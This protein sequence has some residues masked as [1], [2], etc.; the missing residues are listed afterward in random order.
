MSTGLV[1]NE[2][3]VMKARLVSLTA[4][5]VVALA[6][7]ATAQTMSNDCIEG[8][9]LGLVGVPDIVPTG[10]GNAGDPYVYD[11]SGIDLDMDAYDF[12]HNVQ[13][14]ERIDMTLYADS[15]TNGTGGN[16]NFSGPGKNANGADLRGVVLINTTN[17]LAI[18]SATLSITNNV[19]GNGGHLT[20]ISSFGSITVSEEIDTRSGAQGNP[21][22]EM[23]GNVL[24]SAASGNVTVEGS[25]QTMGRTAG[26]VV[27]TGQNVSVGGNI[28]TDGPS[29]GLYS[30]IAGDISITALNGDVVV[31]GWCSA[32]TNDNIKGG[33][34]GDLTISATNG[35]ISLGN[36]DVRLVENIS[37][38]ALTTATITGLIEGLIVEV[39][40]GNVAGA[41]DTDANSDVHY[42][43]DRQQVVGLKGN[44][45]IH[46]L[47]GTDTGYDLVD[48]AARCH[49]RA[50]HPS[51]LEMGTGA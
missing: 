2:L 48:D 9:T 37:L 19:R 51:P 41:F 42:F 18:R 39:A 34:L 6:L 27:V 40:G 29:I 11:V 13:F 17:D 3:N 20:L 28:S 25:I 49:L 30:V 4:I 8:E 24:L 23:G 38:M 36:L 33:T 35:S 21:S 50:S 5:S 26:S 47:A 44:F 22:Q 46:N 15:V 43:S 31:G 7:P 12:L 10:T 16:I 14:P 1:V 32:D 45:N